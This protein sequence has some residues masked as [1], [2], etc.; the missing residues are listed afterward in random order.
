M[1]FSYTDLKFAMYVL[2]GL[3]G[4]GFMITAVV[5]GYACRFS[6][7]PVSLHLTSII[8]FIVGAGMLSF[9]GELFLMRDEQ[10][11]WR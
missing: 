10:D 8:L 5:S 4:L 2:L 1:Y 3:S 7:E 6:V 9:C 11:T